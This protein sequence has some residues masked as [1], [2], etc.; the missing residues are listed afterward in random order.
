METILAGSRP[1]RVEKRRDDF[2]T[3]QHVEGLKNDG[4]GDDELVRPAMV[5]EDAAPTAPRIDE[6]A[7]EP[8]GVEDHPHCG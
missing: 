6:T 1:G 5:E 3:A 7:N 2:G 4:G 8:H